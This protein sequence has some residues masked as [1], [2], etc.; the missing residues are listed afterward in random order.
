MNSKLYK[1]IF[2]RRLGCLIAVGEFTRTYGRSF[3]SF[4]KKIINDS[5]T[6]VGK[7]S[8]LAILTGLVFGTLPLLVFA[9]PSLPVNGNIVFGQGNMDV[10]NTTL[11]VTQQSDKLAI[12][13]GSFDIAQGNN[14]IYNQP[15]QQSIALNRVIGR[16][17]SQ[18]YGNLKA[19]GQ[20]FLL[21]PNGIL[22][23]KGA[24]V[25]V[26]ALVASTK[27]MSNHD[28]IS[29][30]YTLTS[31]KQEG[32]LVNQ[33]NLHTTA[34]GYIALIGQQV[35]NQP[36]GVINTPKGKVALASG[37]RVTLNLD[38]GN[39]LGVQVQGEQVNTLLQNGGLIRADGGVIQLTAQG[40]EMLMNTVIDNTGILQARG[41]SEKNGVIYLDGGNEGVV[42]QQGM[43]NVSSQQGRGGNVILIGENIHL[44]AASKIDASGDESGGK[45]LVGGDWQGK[46]K[47]IKNARSVV[48]DKGAH[49]DVSSTHQGAGGTAVLWSEYYTSFYGDIHARGGPLSGDGGQV[50][51]SSQR[52]LQ[53][54]GR[55]DA[56][57]IMGNMGSWLLDPAEVNIVSRGAE[58]GVSVQVGD[59]PAGY[60]KNAQVF[61]PM[62]NITQILNTSINAQLDKGTNVTITTSNGSLTNC[63]WCNIT[64]QAD[65][66]KTAGGDATLTLQAD[67]NIVSSSHNITATTGK[68]NLNLLSGNSIVD[69]TI[70][71][72]NSDVLLNGGDLL[73]KN[74]NKNNTARIIIMG[75]R[76][77]VGN[78]TLEGNTGLASHVGV[79][80][81]NAANVTVAGETRI[82]GESS[83]ANQQ[84]WRG[85]DISGDS[86]LVGKGNMSFTMISNSKSSWMGTFTNATIAGDKN[87]TFQAN[88]NG[89]TSGGVDFTNGSLVS[90]SGNISFD[91][92][93]EI[94]TQT[95]FGLR[96]QGS[97]ISGNNVNVE[98]N[99][100][101]VDGLLLRD[102]HVTA[103][104]GNISANATTTH[105]GL[106][107][108]GN[109]NLNASKN[110]SLQGV[111]TNSTTA[112]AD[113][114][115]MSGNS[116]NVQV[117]MAAGGNISMVAVN[118][119]TEVGST[120]S[121][122]YTNIKAQG[123][124]F[125]LNISGIKGS[126]FSNVNI[127]ADNIILN[128]N[129]S[130]NDA[131]VMTNTF[132]TAKGDIKAN[133]SSPNHKAL[134][135]KGNGG[136]SAGQN[137]SLA[138]NTSGANVEAV[139]IT[140]TASNR[141][142]VTVGKD[143][144][145]IANNHGNMTGAGIGV[146]YVNFAAKNGNF[147]ANNNG[148]K[149]IG[150]ANTNI[151]ANE[152][153]LISNTS[154]ADGVVI[155]EADITTLTG[156]INANAT[157]TNRGIVIRQNTTFSA[158][159]DLM[160]AATSSTASEAIL[161]QG[162][163]DESRSH[164][165]AQ[166][167]ISLKGN[168]SKGSNPRSSVNLANV[169]LT[170]VGKN[171]D[172]NS[173]SAGDGDVYFNNVALNAVLGNVTV[174]GEALSALSTATNSV[175]SLGGNNSIKALN[176]S[177]IGKAINTTQ[178]AGTLFRANGSLSVAGNIAIQGETGGTGAIRHGIAF[179]GAN[180]L[181]IAK[182]S[183]L[184]LLGENTGSEM[185][186][187]GNGISYLSPNTLTIN[188]NSSLT[189]EG[190]ST[191]GAGINF[192]ISNNTV[193]LN[194][195]GD[196]LIKGSS[197]AGSGVA[198][199]GVVNNSSGPVTIEGTSTDGSGVHLFS[200]E[201]QINRI[202][203]TGSSIQAEGLRISGN[204]T[205]TDT[206]LTGKSI[207][208]SGIKIDSL[209]GSGVITHTI[210]DNAA[211][212][213]SSAHGIGVETTSDINGIH[214]SIINGTTD[215]V[216]YGIDIGENLHVTGTSET[217]L[218][219]L[220]GTATTD[221]GTG[222]KLNGNNDLSNTSLNGSTV[223]GIALDIS[224]SL[225]NS[226]NT[227]LNGIASGDGI[228]V[229]VNGTLN[230]S[231]VN[232][233][234]ASG[235]GVQV[236]G[237][238]DD[239]HVT[240]ISSGG[241]GVKVGAETV[242][243]N[244]MLKGTSTDGIG[245]EITANMS[246]YYGS[247]VQGDVTDG[248]GVMIDRN[249]LLVG[250]DTDDL[251]VI[252]GNA[253]GDHGSGVQLNG[254]NTLDNT[255]LAGSATE[256]VGIDIDG[257]LTNKGNST[258]DGKATDGD[259]VQL[260]GVIAG[261]TVNGTS[262][263]GSGIKVD[264]DSELDNTT[265]NGNSSDGKGIDIAANL[266]G[267]HSSAVHGET[268]DGTGVNVGPNATL[269]GG[270]ADDQLAVT[271]DARS[272]TGSGI[273][274]NGNNTLD[275]TTL[276]GSATEG[277]GIDIDGP[278]TN[279]G[280][281]TL[282]GKATDDGYGVQLNG[283]ISGGTVNG[284]SDLGSGI[285]VDGDSELDNA[286][287][288]GNSSDGKGIEIAANLTGNH[289]SAVHGES[290]EGIGVDIGPNATLTG[291]GADDL[292]AVTG[293][294]SGDI[295]TGVQLDGN[296]TLDNTTLAGNAT[297]GHG[298]KITGPVSNTG[299]TT[300]NGNATGDGHGIHINGPMSGGSVNGNSAN[301]H[302]IFLNDKAVIAEMALGGNTGSDKP[303]M[304][305][306]LP[307]NIGSNATINGK[308]VDKHSPDGRTKP[309][310][311]STSTS[312]PTQ[313]STPTP[314]SAQ[315]PTPTATPIPTLISEGKT[316]SK[317]IT[318][319]QKES[320]LGSL[321]I[322]RNQI[323]S[324]LDEQIL[325]PPVVTESERDIAANISVA[326]CIPESVTTG[327]EPCDT[328][329]LGKWKPLTK[330]LGQE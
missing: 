9:L 105:K 218:L 71:L 164:L 115:K 319:P 14:V 131:V 32:K 249:T 190:R 248:T 159:K 307:E 95:S 214:Q 197:V 195:D 43:I 301:N 303:L 30:S 312:T 201:H 228:G 163:S 28:F 225:T 288:N 103:T 91:I 44:V 232:G 6:K 60:V 245:V 166:G 282:D 186:A 133:L 119:G 155:R 192:P 322:K 286:T 226:G 134:Y 287:L 229:Q 67:G 18:I 113:A 311:T 153:N 136:M 40:K 193:V 11:T 289:G 146:D 158:Q 98:I 284:T 108:S 124:D 231:V 35:D 236:S 261:G 37:S 139:T 73:V 251:L 45:V 93:G 149:S 207:N 238:L 194:G 53:A 295:G 27:S 314:T 327:S 20:V 123:G 48:M 23:G 85:I 57:A 94:T 4:G 121:A 318:Q 38:R 90:K 169:S 39:L 151:R 125:N 17:A 33:A 258:L 88:A 63:R 206:A 118:K 330:T 177:L 138:V 183:Q 156:N 321:L 128:G 31:Q 187:G 22:F 104:A 55:V 74:S 239:S 161:V 280:N 162:V 185:T 199:S 222:I 308:P 323:L 188:N 215:G 233:T 100:K 230:N 66:N 117:N 46:N 306:A 266:T 52:N 7:L 65:I 255:T 86:V 240:G 294:A 202:N 204:A 8:H 92:N 273:Q 96:V 242:L 50:E 203:V 182:D 253:T 132:L 129:V 172:I 5:H 246:G 297:D 180:T 111:T 97:Q 26:G 62:A 58:N 178:G 198:I 276:A 2:C 208:G 196:S 265:L 290:D 269:T 292:L 154:R 296:N 179:Y 99:T 168:N 143:I 283:A 259:G 293:N 257:P 205:I 126:P 170:S 260:N 328:H 223:D 157:S 116:S 77:Q 127:S 315:T 84:G 10:N 211:L 244:T 76:Y 277:V 305:I 298:V 274:L 42:S 78:L 80:I 148:S 19:N 279:K 281:S 300:I 3:S 144:S 69:S 82:T 106:W 224:G 25:D 152:V 75:G 15:G 209:P 61:T 267:N 212:N 325:P 174:Y 181:N 235:V 271:G 135:F 160:L 310:P 263:L 291:G 79:N 304:F 316:L 272:Y 24:Q 278:L 210:L 83:N 89:S 70:T 150:I 56:S 270:G 147:T 137:L 324:S 227:R 309:D 252:N 184:S 262:E 29:G 109:T 87:I 120:I 247:S 21:N 217:D 200:A 173:S 81:S 165:V 329:I 16:D 250:G 49:I 112:G 320:K 101:G 219:T 176:G 145:I 59:I 13:W 36:S 1:L 34:G 254:N 102:S 213:G 189:M 221:S 51:T 326:V 285:K 191:S 171:I 107:I 167:N 122:D 140:G 237:S 256:G 264:G 234:S 114:I 41:L 220:Q 142:N 268:T 241:S 64:L 216:G 12:N 54:F 313:I 47:L 72:N 302:G 299:N 130:D 275:N 68:L 243:N 175:L 110:I 141:M 317:Q